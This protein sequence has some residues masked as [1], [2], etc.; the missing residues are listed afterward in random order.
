[1][2]KK[3]VAK[4]KFEIEG[5]NAVPGQKLGPALG[6]HGINIGEFVNRFNQDTQERRGELVPVIL[7]LF[8]DRTFTLT[9]LQPPVSFLIKKALGIQKGSATANQNKVGKLNKAQLEEIAKRKMADFNTNNLESA[10]NIVAGTAKSMG[11]EVE[12]K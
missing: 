8:D 5:A 9:Y 4:I 6:Q 11:V 3:A 2:A 12:A 10:M 7:T 1:M